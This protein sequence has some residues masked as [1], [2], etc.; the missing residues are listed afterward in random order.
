MTDFEE[1]SI[2]EIENGYILYAHGKDY[3][4]KLER[5]FDTKIEALVCLVA[6]LAEE[7]KTLT[8]DEDVNE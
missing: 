1:G 5:W 6:Y 3:S 7:I 8:E 4:E 2:R